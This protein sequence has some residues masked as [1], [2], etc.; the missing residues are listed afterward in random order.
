MVKTI[1]MKTNALPQISYDELLAEN[2][3]LKA[4]VARLQDALSQASS[5]LAWITRQVFGKH[6]EKFYDNGG[7]TL[8]LFANLD[9]APLETNKKTKDSPDEIKAST[10]DTIAA[11]P[12][13]RGKTQSLGNNTSSGLRIDDGVEIITEDIF[14]DEVKGLSTADYEIIDCEISDRLVSR[15][16]KRVV[17]RRV[18]HK[19]KIKRSS[20]CSESAQCGNATQLPSMIL[21]A[22]VPKQVLNRS[23]MAVSFLVDM[24]LD[25][26]LYSLPLYRQHQSL[27]RE[28]LH[29]SRSALTKNFIEVCCILERLIEPQKCSILAGQTI[30]IDETPMRVEPD[31]VKH[32][33]KKGYVW[34]MYGDLDEIVYVYNESRSASVV[35]ELLG[36]NFKGTILTDGYK[37]Y[38]SYMHAISDSNLGSN[39]V[40]ATCWVHARR[41]FV[42]L[43]HA[44]PEVHKTA[45]MYIGA[46]YE[47]E[48]KLSGKSLTER[49]DTRLS[50]S[51]QLV[52]KYFAWIN[53]LSG[54][55]DI[56]MSCDLRNAL[57]YSTKRESSMREFLK[58]PELSMDTNYLEREIRPIAIGRKNWM[59]CWTEIGAE[60]LCNAQ[61]LVRTCL[62]QGVD[63]RTYLIDIL[64]RLTLLRP[65]DD[66]VSDLIPRLWKEEYGNNPIPCPC[67]AVIRQRPT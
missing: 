8:P 29:V 42:K 17:C 63:P 1:V 57:A 65:D 19:V 32:K 10:E 38:N 21:K 37:A 64:Q 50:S 18:F 35:A 15:K 33:M 54:S 34:P 62:L 22:P 49:A 43:E 7:T 61:S 13:T 16:S 41:K 46:L 51:K 60:C 25:K 36:N 9:C 59:F 5:T 44:F 55:A 67:E 30:A 3:F 11:K 28:G 24:I 26:V 20:Q 31:L 58:N 4:E 27:T 53:E 2:A 66:D 48:D 39:V 23:Y 47:I 52:D 56:A 40:H 12:K 14:P 6:S 45:M